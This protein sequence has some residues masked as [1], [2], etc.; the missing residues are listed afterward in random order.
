MMARG[1]T[2]SNSYGQSEKKV[3]VFTFS[4]TEPSMTVQLCS[5]GEE[6]DGKCQERLCNDRTKQR[7]STFS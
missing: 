6:R 7:E 5:T 4:G 1:G 2:Y 3:K